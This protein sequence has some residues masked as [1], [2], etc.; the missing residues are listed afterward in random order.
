MLLNAGSRTERSRSCAGIFRGGR[1]FQRVQAEAA[2][3]R[4]RSDGV[5]QELGG[6]EAKSPARRGC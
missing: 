5:L 2:L 4:G 6:V 1:V 3:V